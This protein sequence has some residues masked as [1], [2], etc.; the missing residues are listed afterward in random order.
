MKKAGEKV[1]S[2]AKSA[3]KFYDDEISPKSVKPGGKYYGSKSAKFPYNIK[4]K[5]VTAKK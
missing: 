1:K 2:T 4:E 5:K 3:K